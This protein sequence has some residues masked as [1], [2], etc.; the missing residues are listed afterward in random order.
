MT[1]DISVSRHSGDNVHRRQIATITGPASYVTGGDP[2]DPNQFRMGK[3]DAILGLVFSDGT[4]TL[5]GWYDVTNQ[6]LLWFDMAGA[7]VA[8]GTDLDAYTAR[9]EVVGT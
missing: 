4:A 7:E 5:L 2:L 6:K 1:V 9:V 8:N 3:I